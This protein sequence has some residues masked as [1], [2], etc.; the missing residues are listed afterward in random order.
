MQHGRQQLAE[1]AHAARITTAGE[2]AA[3]LAHELN[4]PVTSIV[5]FCDAALSI[6]QRFDSKR[7]DELIDV[8]TETVAQ[9]RRAGDII[10]GLRRFLGRREP[11]RSLHSID[12]I[13]METAALMRPICDAQNVEL[14]LTLADRL[15]LVPVDK[16]QISQVLVNLIRNSADA[17]VAAN[18]NTRR[19]TISTQGDDRLAWG[20][21][22]T[23]RDTGPGVD[24]DTAARLFKPFHSSKP[25]GLGMGLWISRSI[26]ESHGGRLWA[27]AQARGG[28]TFHFSLPAA[29]EDDDG[30]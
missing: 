27:N 7:R 25:N 5:Q 26:V 16:T 19:I 12:D 21:L 18:S 9:A 20:I 28:A 29:N 3:G 11:L 17:M 30:V 6:A 10:H 13:I 15:P 24:E 22:V 2:I 23:T 1:F 4:Q 14:S 8:L